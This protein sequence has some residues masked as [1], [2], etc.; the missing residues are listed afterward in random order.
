[1]NMIYLSEIVFIGDILGV[2][3]ILNIIEIARARLQVQFDL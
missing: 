1:M 2:F 3:S